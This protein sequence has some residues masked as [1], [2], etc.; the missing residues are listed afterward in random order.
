MHTLLAVLLAL[1]PAD[2]PATPDG[3]GG[4]GGGSIFSGM[5]PILL[6]FLVVMV[7]TTV[8]GG[9]KDRARQK[10]L[11]GLKK[12]DRVVTTGGMLGT[13]VNLDEKNVT[14]EIADKVR[15]KFRRTSVFDY[16]KSD[17]EAQKTDQKKDGA[18]AGAKS[19]AKS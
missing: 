12:H 9:K 19:G 1:P 15:V 16:E 11:E 17:D 3:G 13:V 7:L 2:A 14:L 18:K 6:I 10:R 5:L 8:L 4:G